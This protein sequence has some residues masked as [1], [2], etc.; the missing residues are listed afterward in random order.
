M[1]FY[2]DEDPGPLGKPAAPQISDNE[3]RCGWDPTDPDDDNPWYMTDEEIYAAYPWLKPLPTPEPLPTA[4]PIPVP[5]PVPTP[6]PVTES[7]GDS[8][9]VLVIDDTSEETEGTVITIP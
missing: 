1:E 3:L 7:I 8:D 9:D 5:T 4:E 6:A 2:G